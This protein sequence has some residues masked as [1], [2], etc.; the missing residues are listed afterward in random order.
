MRGRLSKAKL[1]GLGK[2]RKRVPGHPGANGGLATVAEDRLDD[3]ESGGSVQ[4]ADG[5][6]GMSSLEPSK[7]YNSNV[8]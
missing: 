7:R 2:A 5:L 4:H 3:R 6:K 1:D 8:K